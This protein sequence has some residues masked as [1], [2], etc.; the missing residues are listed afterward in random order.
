STRSVRAFCTAGAVARWCVVSPFWTLLP[1]MIFCENRD[2]PRIESRAAVSGPCA[3]DRHV[4][5]NGSGIRAKDETGR[6]LLGSVPPP[7]VRH[8][9]GGHRRLQ[10][11]HLDAERRRRL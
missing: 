11:R 7:G 2:P 9:V 5:R 4:G 1:R 8:P 3:E 10:Y 6:I